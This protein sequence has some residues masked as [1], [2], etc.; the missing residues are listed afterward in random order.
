MCAHAVAQH[1]GKSLTC[2]VATTW[3]LLQTPIS[4]STRGTASSGEPAAAPSIP[5]FEAKRKDGRSHLR[6]TGLDARASGLE[7]VDHLRKKISA[8]LGRHHR[9]LRLSIAGMQLLPREVFLLANGYSGATV[10]VELIT[11]PTC[12]VCSQ[13]QNDQA[14]GIGVL[15]SCQV[16]ICLDCAVRHQADPCPRCGDTDHEYEDPD[17][18]S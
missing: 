9:E 13:D 15:D 11:C 1:A 5:L 12:I 4:G 6:K 10:D 16:N 14:A 2:S 8:H 7:T 3:A 17:R 18:S